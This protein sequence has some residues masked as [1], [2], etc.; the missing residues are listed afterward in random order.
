MAAADRDH[1]TDGRAI[2]RI[3]ISLV[4][5]TAAVLAGWVY[6]V[7]AP[8]GGE[9]V[10]VVDIPPQSGPAIEPGELA[11]RE[12]V[13]PERVIPGEDQPPFPPGEGIRI[14]DPAASVSRTD[15][16]AELARAPFA[17]LAETTEFGLLP[18]IG[19]GG[20][21]ASEAY[22][23]PAP[24]IASG[25]AAPV[26]AAL[27]V[28]GLGI[29][30]NGT[31]AAISSLPADVTL[32]FA[33][34]GGDLQTW[35]NRARSDG[36]EVFLQIPMEPFDYPDNDPGPHTLLTTL[37]DADN[38]DRLHW[39]LARFAGYVGVTNYMGAKLTSSPEALG[40]VMSELSARGL[41]FVDDG[42]SS[43]SRG[44]DIAH[45]LG[46]PAVAADVAIAA[47]AT[48]EDI[49]ADLARLE[50]IATENGAAL[51]IA[52]ALPVTIEV[53]TDWSRGLT[54]RGIILVPASA[55]LRDKTS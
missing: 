35:V 44:V 54:S 12:T 42:T 49:N 46:A 52:P 11:I 18:K 24:T 13:P 2:T 1:R 8:T 23:R 17:G 50:A 27:V 3:A 16:R 28:T 26:R 47:D 41:A 7:A 38:L 31:S 43:R 5:A 29:S 14:I 19:E 30:A 40:P 32:A 22:A 45:E 37:E 53:L 39:L 10:V 25:P 55:L 48:R 34:Y 4:A 20:R 6:F 33:P 15:G 9:P 51:A 36:H 21:T